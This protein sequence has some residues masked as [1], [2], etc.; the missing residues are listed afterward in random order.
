M[1]VLVLEPMFTAL[2]Q[3]DVDV[4]LPNLLKSI[5]LPPSCLILDQAGSNLGVYLQVW[6]DKMDLPVEKVKMSPFISDLEQTL[7]GHLRGVEKADAVVAFWRT[8]SSVIA[9]AV[10]SACASKGIP[11]VC[12]YVW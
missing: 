6:A 5:G 10:R 1:K 8:D 7:V 12:Y 4:V 11:L 9:T 2:K 3:E